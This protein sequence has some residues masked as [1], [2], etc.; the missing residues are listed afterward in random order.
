MKKLFIFAVGLSI[1]M[2]SIQAHAAGTVVETLRLVNS[3]SGIYT[4]TFLCTADSADGSFPSTAF[5]A[6]T[7]LTLAGW[8]LGQMRINP[9]TP[10]PTALYDIAINDS[11]GG[12]VCGGALV[13]MSATLTGSRRAPLVESA[14]TATGLGS[15][16]MDDIWT[17]VVT[18]NSVNSAVVEVT[19]FF[20]K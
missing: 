5:S 1:L 20:S 13:D 10:A 14:G 9:G 11:A 3:Y 17:L 12:D 4:V 19:L 7:S 2:C 16:T 8:G 15:V 6:P 18:G